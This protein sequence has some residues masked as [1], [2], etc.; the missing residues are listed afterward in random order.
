MTQKREVEASKE[1]ISDFTQ[2]MNDMKDARSTLLKNIEEAR[3]AIE[4]KKE[5]KCS[6][7]HF[8]DTTSSSLL[9]NILFN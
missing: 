3:A 8:I 2:K 7:F 6:A 1:T 9:I 4:L 5:G